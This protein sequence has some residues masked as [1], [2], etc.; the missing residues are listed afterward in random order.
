MCHVTNNNDKEG[1]A[2]IK[3]AINFTNEQNQHGHS[4]HTNCKVI[5]MLQQKLLNFFD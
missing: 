1:V 4:H 3:M 2:E 5:S